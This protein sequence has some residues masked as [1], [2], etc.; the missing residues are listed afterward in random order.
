M[1]RDKSIEQDA[2]RDMQ[3]LRHREEAASV[4]LQEAKEARAHQDG[5][6]DGVRIETS[7]DLQQLL[8]EVGQA[9]S[10]LTVSSFLHGLST[11]QLKRIKENQLYKSG[12]GIRLPVG[13][14]S[15]T[16]DVGSFEG[17]CR[18]IGVSRS[19]VDEDIRNLDAFGEELLENLKRVGLGYRDLRK[20]RHLPEPERQA[21]IQGEAVDLDDKESVV[22]LIED[23]EAKHQR[24][25]E[26]FERKNEDL[27]GELDASRR[28]ATDK[29]EKINE[30]YSRLE[31]QENLGP[32][33]RAEDLSRELEQ[34]V[35]A[36]LGAML[37]LDAVI[38]TILEWEDAPRE[39]RH[40]CAQAIARIRVGLEELQDRHMLPAVDLDVD[41]SWMA[42]SELGDRAAAP[43]AE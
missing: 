37:K 40:A 26:E 28:W 25:R 20:L 3:E 19:K 14:G 35:H 5:Q 17:F 36:P 7:G 43:D 13:D 9:R 24:E 22:S 1:E 11:V 32:K 30:L 12:K 39:L 2:T 31:R 27:K 4:D 15:E 34:A 23:L 41:D 29:D 16:A 6:G 42:E 10:L 38:G 18:A 33:E 21:F 8:I